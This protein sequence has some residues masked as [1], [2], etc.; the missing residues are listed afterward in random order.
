MKQETQ[1]NR[2]NS[3]RLKTKWYNWLLV[4]LIGLVELLLLLLILYVS[5]FSPELKSAKSFEVY[6]IIAVDIVLIWIGVLIGYYTW[7]VYFHNINLGLTNEDW[8]EIREKKARGE[9]VE[10][11]LENPNSKNTLGLPE[12]TIR[13]TLALSLA[14][15]ALAMLIASLGKQNTLPPNEIFV[16]TFDFFKTAFLM[17]IAFYFGNKSIETFKK[18]SGPSE[19]MNTG[20]TTQT[21]SQSGQNVTATTLP[22]AVTNQSG[23]LKKVLNQGGPGNV[24]GKGEGSPEFEDANAQG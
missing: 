6:N 16:D 21:G 3:S 8:A 7:A 13:G 11:R 5:L 18:F 15:G 10:E 20:K 17:M 14:I 22:P 24:S 12:G 9:D 1:E 4:F 23:E 2:L 19:I